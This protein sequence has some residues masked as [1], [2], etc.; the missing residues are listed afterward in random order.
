M[1]VEAEENEGILRLPI[2]NVKKYDL[3]SISKNKFIDE[4]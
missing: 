1:V 2:D 4:Y 3:H